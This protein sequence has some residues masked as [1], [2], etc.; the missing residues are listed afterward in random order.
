M[1]C[2]TVANGEAKR[3]RTS[4]IKRVLKCEST[5]VGG[6]LFVFINLKLLVEF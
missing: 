6:V 2:I 3:G 5:V 1:A 4:K